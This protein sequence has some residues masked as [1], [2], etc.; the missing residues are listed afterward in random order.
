MG[1]EPLIIAGHITA[2]AKGRPPGG[3]AGRVKVF[4]HALHDDRRSG[5]KYRDIGAVAPL[6]DDGPRHVG[7]LAIELRSGSPQT[8]TR[9]LIGGRLRVAGQL[10]AEVAVQCE[11]PND[12]AGTA[13]EG[14]RIT[15]DRLDFGKAVRAA[16]T[17]ILR[18]RV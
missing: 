3:L 1:T 13:S 17:P 4:L 14:A 9:Y 5:P 18:C 16:F 6:A 7:G 12:I 15:A 10:L 11:A 8:Q 2:T